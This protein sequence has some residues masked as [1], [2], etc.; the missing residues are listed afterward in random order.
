[1]YIYIYMYVFKNICIDMYVYIYIHIHFSGFVYFLHFLAARV[2]S[3]CLR[4]GVACHETIVDALFGG[5]NMNPDDLVLLVDCLPNRQG[6][7]FSCNHVNG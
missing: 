6:H 7:F 3:F 5:M 4:K 1:M 2:S